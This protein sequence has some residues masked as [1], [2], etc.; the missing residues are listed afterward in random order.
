MPPGPPAHGLVPEQVLG[1]EDPGFHE[2][3]LE[4]LHDGVYLVDRDCR[5]VYWNRGA[6]RIAGHLR[7]EVIGRRCGEEVLSHCTAL[8]DTLCGSN[9]PLAAALAHGKHRQAEAYLRHKRGHRL[10]VRVRA[11]PIHDQHGAIVGA[12]E[13]FE[14]TS[15]GA[16]LIERFKELGP[17]GCIDALTG[18]ATHA[19]T[20]LRLKHRLEE[21]QA[22]GIPFGVLLIDIDH[23]KAHN[24]TYGYR[25]GDE[26]LRVV[27]ESM[28][29]AV[30]SQAFLG[31]WDREL[32]LGILAKCDRRKLREA[33]ERIRALV[34]GSSIAWW[35]DRIGLT[36]SV[37][38][39]LVAPGDDAASLLSRAQQL[40]EAAQERGGNQVK[41]EGREL[42]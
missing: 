6:E 23:L 32:F 26:M 10:P 36:V 20:E 8:G 27:A 41:L 15:P 13:V 31:R 7:H 24:L 17:F 1:I 38:G 2:A 9:C 29:R 12:V 39:C 3:L 19:L 22:F 18:L 11:S 34:E 35:G 4:S 5:I 28:A 37:G 21:F 16:G 42:E 40:L 30:G 25:A 33:G 14:E